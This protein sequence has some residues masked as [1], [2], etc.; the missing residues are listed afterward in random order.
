MTT[1]TQEHFFQFPAIRCHQGGRVQYML[2]APMNML[3]R[4]MAFDNAGDVM[5]R[6]QREVHLGR[7]KKVTGYLTSG[8]DNKTDYMLPTLVG[9]ID[10][11]VR[12][13]EAEG[14]KGGLPA[15]LSGRP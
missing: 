5:S 1:Q 15:F 12:F 4:I 11:V 13:E 6:S 9:N 10:G 2:C 14:V 7:A 8:Y 3:K